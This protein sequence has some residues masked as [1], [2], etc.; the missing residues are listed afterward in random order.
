MT[1]PN[2]KWK[3]TSKYRDTMASLADDAVVLLGC[4]DEQAIRLANG[5]ASDYGN[6]TLRESL[7]KNGKSKS[8]VKGSTVDKTGDIKIVEIEQMES[9]GQATPCIR[10]WNAMYHFNRI[11]KHGYK[12]S[13]T[14]LAL[15]SEL[16]DWLFPVELEKA[17]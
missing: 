3:F 5:F 9:T 6:R 10:I 2:E 13:D 12:Y 16:H 14:H 4:T 7:D 1:N 17:A 15:V 11:K 8:K